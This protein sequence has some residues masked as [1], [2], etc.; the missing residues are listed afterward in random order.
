MKIFKEKLKKNPT[1]DKLKCSIKTFQITQKK[2][3]IRQK[4]NKHRG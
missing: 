1:A 4:E 2:A 3:G